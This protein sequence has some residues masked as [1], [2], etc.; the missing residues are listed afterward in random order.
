MLHI[1]EI[2]GCGAHSQE[3][4]SLIILVESTQNI[5]L[6]LGIFQGRICEI[7]THA[8]LLLEGNSEPSASTM[9]RGGAGADPKTGI[10]RVGSTGV[11]PTVASPGKL[12]GRHASPTTFMVTFSATCPP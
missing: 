10:G 5:P 4:K 11:H 7:D 8:M 2:R 9:S 1:C 6:D 3:E 12:F